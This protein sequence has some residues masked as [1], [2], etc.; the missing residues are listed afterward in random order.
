MTANETG[1]TIEADSEPPPPPAAEPPPREQTPA[2]KIFL[3]L[4]VLALCLATA[5]P[6]LGQLWQI[7]IARFG[8][9]DETPSHDYVWL[10]FNALPEIRLQLAIIG[11]VLATA[12]AAFG[13]RATTLIAV[14]AAVVN[15]AVI[16]QSIDA[17]PPTPSDATGKEFRVMTFNVSAFNG[18][19]GAGFAAIRAAKA[20]IVVLEE[21]S[22]GWPR[23]LEALR[24][25]YRYAAPDNVAQSRGMMILSRYPITWS[26]QM[27]PISKYY[28]YVAAVLQLPSTTVTLLAIHPPRPTRIGE[29]VDRD[30]YFE[31]VAQHVRHLDGPILVMGDFTAVPW[32]QAFEALTRD[33]GLIKAWS[34]KPWLTSWP[35][36]LPNLGLPIDQILANDAFAITDVR[37]GEDGGSDHVPVIATLRLRAQ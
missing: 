36:W 5:A 19:H 7:F 24:G 28:P 10:V 15:A 27:Q 1:L 18:D 21:A 6:V 9:A 2:S 11:V 14:F 17:V 23:A 33:T 3:V 30:I 31:R 26:E 32:S 35:S 13:Y 12:A 37:L 25:D 4:A 8:L 34:L 29:S 20:D 16:V 22:H